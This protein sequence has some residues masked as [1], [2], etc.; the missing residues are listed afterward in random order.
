MK[1]IAIQIDED[2]AQAFQSS[3]PEQQQQIQ[4]WL[5]QWMRQALKISK[6]QNTM[7]RLSDEAVSNGLTPEILQA[8]I[9]E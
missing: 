7:D 5:N 2:I 1:T 4:A 3:Q 6:L 8:I 9:N